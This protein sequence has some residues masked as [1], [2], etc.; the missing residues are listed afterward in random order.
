VLHRRL[1]QQRPDKKQPQQQLQ[2]AASLHVP[3]CALVDVSFP[4]TVKNTLILL[5]YCCSF[6]LFTCSLNAMIWESSSLP[7]KLTCPAF[8]SRSIAAGVRCV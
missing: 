6:R 1:Q 4:N 8:S 3:L 2:D 5:V 7:P